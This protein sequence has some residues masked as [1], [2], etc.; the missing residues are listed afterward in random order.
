MLK[1]QQG[2]GNK[3]SREVEAL[4]QAWSEADLVSESRFRSHR[5]VSSKHALLNAR[6]QEGSEDA[7]L[8][9]GQTNRPSRP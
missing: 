3:R 6:T 1:A 9:G 4:G 2:R 5:K 7:F 8:C